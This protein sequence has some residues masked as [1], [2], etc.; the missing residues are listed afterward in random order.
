MFGD[1]RVVPASAADAA[2][3]AEVMSNC[4]STW[5]PTENE[6]AKSLSTLP[7][8]ILA[9]Y[10]LGFVDD[11]AVAHGA[12]TNDR[13]VDEPTIWIADV[14][15]IEPYQRRGCGRAMAGTLMNWLT[16]VL[17]DQYRGGVTPTLRSATVDSLAGDRFATKLG[18]RVQETRYVSVL[19][20]RAADLTQFNSIDERMAELGVTL[21][22]LAAVGEP[23]R[24]SFE[25]LLFDLDTEAMLDEPGNI[26][27]GKVGFEAWRAEHVRGHDPNGA[28]VA[29]H[30]ERPIGLTIHW[31]EGHELLVASTVVKREWRGKGVATALKVA[32]VRYARERGKPLRAFNSAENPAILAVNRRLGFVRVQTVTKWQADPADV[33]SRLLVG[34]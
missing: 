23:E 17:D 3:I 5:K 9:Q 2:S 33:R 34:S 21:T 7:D 24:E 10:F 1:L 18:F 11:V 22:T 19:D 20:P 30:G 16:P 31:D 6:I 8:H 25:R 28:I 27:M 14:F 26:G 4:G 32:G 15:V 29:I 13:Y 12:V